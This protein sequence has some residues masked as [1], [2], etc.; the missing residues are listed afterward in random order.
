MNGCSVRIHHGP[1]SFIQ[2]PVSQEEGR[3]G[4]NPERTDLCACGMETPS[5]RKK[6]GGPAPGRSCGSPG[7]WGQAGPAIW[8]WVRAHF[9]VDL[10]SGP[11]E[12]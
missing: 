10:G 4:F 9:P 3:M 11:G 12:G 5:Y 8:P 2:F 6:A 1:L 7:S